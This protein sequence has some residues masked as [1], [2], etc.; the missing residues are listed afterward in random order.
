MRRLGS[1]AL[2]LCY[3]AAGRLDG[4]YDRGIMAWDVAAGV[5]IVEEAG[6]RVTDY[7]GRKLDMGEG[8]WWRATAPC[9]HSS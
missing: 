2:G 1:A 6:E 5:L 8:R 4:Y 9:T 7:R 3:A